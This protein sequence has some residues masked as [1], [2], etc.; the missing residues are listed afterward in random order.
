[1]KIEY[2]YA[3]G[4]NWAMIAADMVALIVGGSDALAG[5]GTVSRALCSVEGSAGVGVWGTSGNSDIYRLT[6]DGGQISGEFQAVTGGAVD[7]IYLMMTNAPGDMPA[8]PVGVMVAGQNSAG[9]GQ[10][11]A[12]GFVRIAVNDYAVAF[13][14]SYGA[15]RQLALIGEADGDFFGAGGYP[16]GFVVGTQAAAAG[17]DFLDAVTRVPY[18]TKLKNHAAAGDKLG[19]AACALAIAAHPASASGSVIG[20]NESVV[21]QA[22]PL[23]LWSSPKAVHYGY[24]RGVMLAPQKGIANDEYLTIAG[25]NYLVFREN[26]TA[27]VA[28][29][30]EV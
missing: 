1:M 24:V 27:A 22:L 3:A 21:W 13:S 18:F 25:K 29:A 8:G 9:G 7:G 28:F 16:R 14:F 4:E 19:L 26:A 20:V 5:L 17:G 11:S 30:L 12:D 10:A 6:A 23:E 15:S 2:A